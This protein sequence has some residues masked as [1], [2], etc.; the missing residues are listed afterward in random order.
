MQQQHVGIEVLL[1]TVLHD[2]CYTGSSYLCGCARDRK[3]TVQ[4]P[5]GQLVTLQKEAACNSYPCSVGCPCYAPY[6]EGYITAAVACEMQKQSPGGQPFCTDQHCIDLQ[7]MAKANRERLAVLLGEIQERQPGDQRYAAALNGES[8]GTHSTGTTTG[9]R[10]IQ[11]LR[12][13]RQTEQEGRQ[14]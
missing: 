2:H 12:R 1:H 13:Q 4:S 7:V 3:F 6:A 5:Y 10:T 8:Y 11:E 14:R 9:A